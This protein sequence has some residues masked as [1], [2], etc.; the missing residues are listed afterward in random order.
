MEWESILIIIFTGIVAFMGVT[1]VSYY[2][3]LLAIVKSSRARER[4]TNLASAEHP[5]ISIIVCTFNE[6]STVEGKLLDLLSQDYPV[7]QM[8]VIVMDSGS[9]DK[10]PSVVESFAETHKTL[11]LRLLRERE[12]RGK[13][14][15]LNI[16]IH[17]VNSNSEIVVITDCDSRF[18]K[19]SLKHAVESFADPRVGLV[20]GVQTLINPNESIATK[21]ESTYRRFYVLVR[22]GESLIDS[23]PICNGELVACRRQVI[24]RVPLRDNV[25]TDDVQLA[26]LTRRTGLRSICNPDA[27]FYE[28]APPISRDL[29]R[30]KIR[31][32]QGI[33]RTL[34]ANRDLV[35][36]KEFGEYGMLIFPM[37]FF[38]HI[39]SPVIS[40]AAIILAIGILGVIMI[41]GAVWIPIVIAAVG[42]LTL[43][44][45]PK[46]ARMYRTLMSFTYY[47]LMLSYA[48]FLALMGRSL[49]KWQKIESVRDK[50][51][52]ARIDSPLQMREREVP[53]A[54]QCTS[55][56]PD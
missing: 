51:R 34:W 37:N 12:R 17:E 56:M 16:A 52:W 47:Q 3:Y 27:G 13:T 21:V 24:Q 55:K 35:F 48:I 43:L 18:A 15:A 11:N 14:A 38:M 41:E 32:G 39:V 33:V 7:D 42:A 50:Q 40:V 8:E 53:A 28:F 4:Q 5:R 30:Q 45:W 1:Y 19:N 2:R 10:T 46:L 31:R 23:T 25:N 29:R 54:A 49:H 20:M 6:E 9:S 22:Q 26:I 44:A 36:N